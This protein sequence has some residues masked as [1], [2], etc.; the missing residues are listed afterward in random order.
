MLHAVIMAGGAGSRFWPESRDLRPKQ[1]LRLAGERSLIQS[2]VE[3]L[4]DV[5]PAERVLIVTG[6][7]LAAGIREQLP[8]LPPEA[9]L[10]E[11]CRRDTAPCIGWAA[12]RLLERDPQATMVVLPA[13]HVIAPE[14]DFRRAVSFAS[15]L[16]DESPGR[17]VTFGIRPTYPAESFGY[18]ERGAALPGEPGAYRAVRFKEKPPAAVAEQYL[19]AGNFLWN[20]GIF[21]WKAR[22]IVD[23]LAARQPE[24]IAHLRRIVAAG[25]GPDAAAVLEREFA[26]IKGVSID[27]AVMEHATDVVVVEAPFTWD[28]VGSWQALARLRGSDAAGN[29]IVGRHL[30]IATERSIVHTSDAHL[31]VTLGL[32]DVLVVH[33]SDATLVANRR[34]EEQV[35]QVVKL[36]REQGWTDYL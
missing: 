34:D 15:R 23:A 29:T 16:V 20:S 9:V 35:R 28:D 33:T 10:A 2:T 26:E 25:S 17:I 18:I 6:A 32:A 31:V 5:V 21:V 36:L 14:A 7:A 8:A 11:P 3:R 13:D 22:T 1:L 30:G 12:L 27:Y 19:A 24:M 4:G